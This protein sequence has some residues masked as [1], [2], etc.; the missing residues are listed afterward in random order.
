MDCR[1][2]THNA[3][4]YNFGIK[5]NLFNDDKN[6]LLSSLGCVKNRK[7][8]SPF[9][10]WLGKRVDEDGSRLKRDEKSERGL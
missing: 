2:N 3:T 6:C 4:Q 1:L 7:F 5:T 8:F 9:L 10:G